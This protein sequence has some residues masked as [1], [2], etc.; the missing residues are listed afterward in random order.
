MTYRSLLSFTLGLFLILNSA[1]S[2]A[3]T[4][5]EDINDTTISLDS[6]KGK[7]VLINF[8]AS[9]C[10]PC[11]DEIAELNQFY[12]KNKAHNVAVFAV[13]YESLPLYKQQR[14]IR[15]FDIHYPSLKNNSVAQLH[16]GDISVVPVTFILDPEG[17]VAT[18]LYGGQT[19][20]SL[21]EAITSLEQ[22][23]KSRV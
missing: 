22:P 13:N 9:W 10:N 18:A 12:E 17:K 4:V 23:L 19:A 7:W 5:L 21:R 6:L 20:K 3:D 8:W 16:L 1:Y 2:Q 11:V 15:K 14:L